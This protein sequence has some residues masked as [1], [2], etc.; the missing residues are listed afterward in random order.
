MWFCISWLEAVFT[1][2]AYLT[3]YLNKLSDFFRS[4][5]WIVPFLLPISFTISIL[6]ELSRDFLSLVQVTR[7]FCLEKVNLCSWVLPFL[8]LLLQ[9]SILVLARLW[10]HSMQLDRYVGTSFQHMLQFYVLRIGKTTEDLGCYFHEGSRHR[11]KKNLP[12]WI[13]CLSL[14]SGRVII[15]SSWN[16]HSLL[17]DFDDP[18]IFFWLFD[19]KDWDEL[20]SAKLAFCG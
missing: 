17:L 1:E 10:R 8:V 12:D 7:L 18:H 3:S 20:Q 6:T 16:L 5:I 11:R 9:K 19:R 2:E 15:Y 4:P 14:S 13:L